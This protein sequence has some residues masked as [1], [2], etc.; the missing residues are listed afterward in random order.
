MNLCESC[1][2]AP[3]TFHLTNLSPSGE[4]AEQHL[5]DRC[6]LEKGLLQVSKPSSLELIDQFIKAATGKASAADLVCEQ[7]GISY[8]EFRNQGLLG[9]PHDYDAFK[10]VLKPLLDRA[11]EGG[12]HHTGKTPRAA[13]VRRV[14]QQDIQKLRRQLRDAV[15]GEDYERAA[16]LRDRIQKLEGSA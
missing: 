4:K 1:K 12:D 10:D 13:G 2:K 14:P 16:E 9:C 11:H 15:A 6:A 8:F 7:C 3:A 5:C